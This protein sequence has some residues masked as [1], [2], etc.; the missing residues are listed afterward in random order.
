MEQ[1][2]I[3]IINDMC[4]YSR[5]ATTAMMP[6]LMRM[7]HS[8]YNLPTALVSNSFGYGRFAIMETTDYIAET[9]RVWHELGFSFDAI[10]TGF[11]ASERQAELISSFCKQQSDKGARIFVDPIMGD[12]GRLYNGTT[13]KHVV[14]MRRLLSVAHLTF[15]NYTEACYLTD[16]E[17]SASG[18]TN[19]EAHA[20]IDKVRELG[21]RS[22][23]VSSLPVD[24]EMMVAGYNESSASYFFIS[25]DEIPIRFAGTGDVFSAVVIG[26]LLGGA[27]LEESTR[28]AMHTVYRLIDLHKES[29]DHEAGIPI[30]KYGLD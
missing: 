2:K 11:I 17:Y 4:G 14:A 18:V 9:M 30:E 7:G 26:G 10:A 15:P 22:V 25:Y 28:K 5:V 24:G 29:A 8:P 12:E 20:L 16:T 6:I 19:A 21:A 1:K 13:M 27:T 23:I 3:L